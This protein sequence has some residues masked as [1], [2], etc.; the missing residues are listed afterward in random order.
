MAL[1]LILAAVAF[2]AWRQSVADAAV[3][4][5]LLLASSAQQ[6]NQAGRVDLALA[7]AQ[8][9]VSFNQPPAEAVRALRTVALGPGTVAVLRPEHGVR[10]ADPRFSTAGC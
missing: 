2:W 4:S 9:A 10:V 1:T 5:S 6:L 3:S 7:L 8:Q